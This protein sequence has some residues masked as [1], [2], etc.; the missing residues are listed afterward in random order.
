MTIVALNRR[1]VQWREGDLVDPGLRSRFGHYYGSLCWDDLLAKRRVVVLAEAG[2]GKS[3]ELEEQARLQRQTGAVAFF[4]TVEDVGRDGLDVALPSEDLARLASWRASDDAA[5]FFVD[6]VDEAKLSNVRLEKALR[7]LADGIANAERR[8]HVILSSRLTDWESRRDLARFKAALPIPNDPV[9]LP[10]PE[11]LLKSTIRPTR[12]ATEPPPAEEPMVVLMEPLD[13]ERVRLFA[14]AERVT[15]LD[16]FMSQIEE[17]NVWRFAQRPLDLNWLVEFWKRYDRLGT[18]AQMVESSLRERLQESNRDRALHDGLDVT[19]A[20]N[21]IERIGAALVFGRKTTIAI[22]DSALTLSDDDRPLN[23]DDVLPDWSAENRTRLLTRPVFDPATFG[24]ARLHND[25]EGVV[26]GYLAA[27]WLSRLRAVNLPRDTLFDLLFAKT[28]GIDV[29]KPSMRETTAWLAIWNADVACEAAQR[30]P[31][32]LLGAGDPA[33]LSTELRG[34]V[35]TRL[36]E[37]MTSDGSELAILDADRVKRF[38]QRDIANVIGTQWVRHH[39]HAEVRLLLLRLIFLG[40]LTECADLAAD[41][42][43]GAYDDR[44]TRVMAGRALAATGD[45]STK[46]RYV[47]YIQAE[48]TKLPNVL[49]WNA[50]DDLFPE[51]LK[52]D[53]LL[54]PSLRRSTAA[55]TMA[56][57]DSDGKARISSID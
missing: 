10:T 23:L 4:A 46:R 37:Q 22:P 39:D 48:C 16:E 53:D 55:I 12:P 14:A 40:E 7:R 50:I 52:V 27:R 17:A 1:F 15:N 30:D 38:A 36:V 32:L 20:L 21:A 54:E 57:S 49:T 43:F 6:S 35:L 51:T 47:D 13:S 44:D 41:A 45:G 19:R 3:A 9:A 11:E 29:I 18:L 2:S 5:W 56:G 24:R 8:A 26:S 31:A 42:S 25:N 33:S 28:Y 34:N